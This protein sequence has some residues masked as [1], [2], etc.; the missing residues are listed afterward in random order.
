MMTITVKEL[1]YKIYIEILN[2]N[3][4]KYIKRNELSLLLPFNFN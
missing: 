4:H 1:E 3:Y 2:Y